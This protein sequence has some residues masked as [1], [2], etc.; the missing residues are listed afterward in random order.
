MTSGYEGQRGCSGQIL[1]WG[2]DLIQLLPSQETK[3]H[4]LDEYI[5]KSKI[6]L[7]LHRLATIGN[8]LGLCTRWAGIW[9]QWLLLEARK[10]LPPGLKGPLHEALE[11]LP[12]YISRQTQTEQKVTGAT[13]PE[14]NTTQLERVDWEQNVPLWF[15]E[16]NRM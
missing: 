2:L 14:K 13:Q 4:P 8:F 3:A 1:E 7:V 16:W 9:D 15:R 6:P 5:A 12:L 10:A 11:R